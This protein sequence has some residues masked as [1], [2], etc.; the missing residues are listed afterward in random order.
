MNIKSIFLKASK[1]QNWSTQKLGFLNS[2]AF[3]STGYPRALS[4]PS[5]SMLVKIENTMQDVLWNLLRA[6]SSFLVF[7]FSFGM[8]WVKIVYIIYLYL[9]QFGVFLTLAEHSPTTA[10]FVKLLKICPMQHKQNVCLGFNFKKEQL[11]SYDNLFLC[12]A[13]PHL[14]HCFSASAVSFPH[15]VPG[16]LLILDNLLTFSSVVLHFLLKFSL[17]PILFPPVLFNSCCMRLAWALEQGVG[18]DPSSISIFSPRPLHSPPP[19]WA[20]LAGGLWSYKHC[21]SLCNQSMPVQVWAFGAYSLQQNLFEMGAC[22][23]CS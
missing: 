15:P 12:D 1:S 11:L 17:S 7:Y 3:F 10:S 6:F 21:T 13:H 14:F 5:S 2:E 20:H 16:L 22:L 8:C 19:L 4:A 9:R 18:R 23:T